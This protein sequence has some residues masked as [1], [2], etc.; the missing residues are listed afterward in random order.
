MRWVPRYDD[1]YRRQTY[2]GASRV[3]GTTRFFRI[4]KIGS[5]NWELEVVLPHRTHLVRF[6]TKTAATQAAE[7]WQPGWDDVTYGKT[8]AEIGGDRRGGA[9]AG[10]AQGTRFDTWEVDAAV[11]NNLLR[12]ASLDHANGVIDGWRSQLGQALHG[13]A[14]A[15]RQRAEV[16]GEQP[17]TVLDRIAELAELTRRRDAGDHDADIAARAIDL[18]A[19]LGLGPKKFDHQEG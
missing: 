7:R 3:D 19:A 16:A 13:L 5:S 10:Y 1:L 6:Q 18:I 14:A 8:L 4:T 2:C 15:E 11:A 17:Y 12:E 9:S